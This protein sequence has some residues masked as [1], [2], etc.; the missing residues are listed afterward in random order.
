MIGSRRSGFERDTCGLGRWIGEVPVD[1]IADY[2]GGGS[3]GGQGGEGH[4]CTAGTGTWEKRDTPRGGRKET[5]KI[6]SAPRS[7]L[8]CRGA[9]RPVLR[10]LH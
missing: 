8:E 5:A 3:V 1:R 2:Q 10:F 7:V 4:D 9:A 6:T